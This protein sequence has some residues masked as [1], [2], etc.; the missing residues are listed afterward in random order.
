LMNLRTTNLNIPAPLFITLPNRKERRDSR[1]QPG[2]QHRTAAPA[3]IPSSLC[4][5]FSGMGYF[6]M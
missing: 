5:L 6:A 4:Q 1:R 3:S 2:V